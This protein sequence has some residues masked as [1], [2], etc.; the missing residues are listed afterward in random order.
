MYKVVVVP[1]RIGHVVLGSFLGSTLFLIIQLS[2]FA[3]GS[4]TLAWNPN[5]DP[6][7]AG[8]NIYCGTASGAYTNEIDAGNATNVT[9]SGLVPGTAYYFAAT[10]Y[11][12]AGIESTLSSEVAYLV[13]LTA[14]A[15]N[16]PPTLNI[17][18][19]LILNENAG[20]Q[21]VNLS[22]ITSGATNENQV[23][24]LMATSSNTNLIP[25]PTVNYASP[26]TNGS[27]NFTPVALANGTATITVT[28]ND[29][30]ASNNIVTRT[31]TIT[32]NAVNQAP[33][34]NALG[35]LTINKN[36]SAQTVNLSGITSGAPNEDQTL[37]VTATSSNTGLISKPT[38]KYSSP[39]ATGILT[40]KPALNKTGAALIT[41][42]VKDGGRSN[43]IATRTFT[44]MVVKGQPLLSYQL[45][46]QI[47]LAGQSRTFSIK[48]TGQGTLKYQWKYN[49][50]ILSSA[51]SSVLT[52]NNIATNQSGTYSVTVS[53]QNG[54]TNSTAAL[55]VYA[56]ATSV[57][58]R[59]G[60][61]EGRYTM[62]VDG[63][64]GCRYIIQASS[65]FV[66]WDPVQT[67]LAPF[68][69]VDT[70]PDPFNQQFYRSV[71][72]P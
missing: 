54:S 68:T 41:V 33:T 18:G 71:Y 21:T 13:P 66:N 57:L 4:V 30:G 49:G 50:T 62:T 22:S 15:T 20:L 27:L 12:T 35:N 2:A 25:H 37:T 58:T 59:A 8:Y 7:V 48:A 32:V 63:V 45:T 70:R 3:N 26:G 36:V 64:P 61:A 1:G 5:L 31:F 52:L 67:N 46:N 44:V 16:Q 23:L 10:T 11:S 55:T 19:N 24:S 38:V 14:A 53:D 69:F 6:A 47:A 39:S 9:L 34:L 60:Y 72:A 65:D 29:G 17:L 28:V 43:S 56:K 51:A 40:F 42:T